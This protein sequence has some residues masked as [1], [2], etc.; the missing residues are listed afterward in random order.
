MMEGKKEIEE[1]LL[2]LTA[3]KVN[4]ARERRFIGTPVGTKKWKEERDTLNAEIGNFLES[5]RKLRENPPEKSGGSGRVKNVR[6]QLSWMVLVWGGL[7]L[8]KRG[9]GDTTLCTNLTKREKG[10][11]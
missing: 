7:W 1:T 11:W 8:G 9:V 5:G 10:D 2:V 4:R 6:N 3:S